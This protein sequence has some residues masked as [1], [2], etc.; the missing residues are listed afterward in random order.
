MFYAQGQYEHI[1]TTLLPLCHSLDTAGR[2][3]ADTNQQLSLLARAYAN[4][5]QLTEVQNW[6]EKALRA[7]QFNA[8]LHYLLATV[9]LE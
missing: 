9:L 4:Q 2:P 3:T 7:D 6:C 5:G 8:N 1:I